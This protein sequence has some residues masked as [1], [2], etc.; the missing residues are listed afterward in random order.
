MLLS[1]FHFHFSLITLL[2]YM[3]I[4]Y[5]LFL[6]RHSVLIYLYF[7]TIQCIYIMVLTE[8]GTCFLDKKANK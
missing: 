5:N 4:L 3:Y 8:T 7:I 6:V 2:W 1:T